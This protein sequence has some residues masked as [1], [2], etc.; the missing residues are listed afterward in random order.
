M[1]TAQLMLINLKV[2]E[3]DV[4]VYF[5]CRRSMSSNSKL[6]N[7]LSYFKFNYGNYSVD[8]LE[9]ISMMFIEYGMM[10]SLTIL[11]YLIVY[12]QYPGIQC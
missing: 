7:Y 2:T 1:I 3:L 6:G 4:F 8:S 12:S 10:T 11:C 5:N 9:Y